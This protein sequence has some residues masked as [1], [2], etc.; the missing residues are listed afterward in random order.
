MALKEELIRF[1][2]RSADIFVYSGSFHDSLVL[3]ESFRV[4]C[5]VRQAGLLSRYI[6]AMLNILALV[7]T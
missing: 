6:F 1:L 4:G 3:G 7:F 2:W 5:I